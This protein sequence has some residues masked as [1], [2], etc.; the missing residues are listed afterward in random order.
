MPPKD[1][2][3]IDVGRRGEELAAD[4][5]TSNGLEIVEKNFRSRVG[6]IDLIA[7]DEHCLVF[8]EV[9]SL[10]KVSHVRPE[11]TVTITKQRQI[12]RAANAYLSI[13]RARPS[14][15][16][17]DVLAVDLSSDPPTITHYKNA[18]EPRRG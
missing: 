3:R 7:R 12:T 15:C 10:R 9:R 18:F 1:D 5:L 6:E 13:R 2:D 17:F 16:R 4:Y 14:H 8:C 11:D